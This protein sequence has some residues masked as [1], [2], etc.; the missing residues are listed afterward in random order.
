MK[1]I[2][3]SPELYK[4][5][6]KYAY[7]LCKN[8][9]YKLDLVHDGYL[10][11]LKYG[12]PEKVAPELMGAALANH[13]KQ[14]YIRSLKRH[15]NKNIISY[16]NLAIIPDWNYTTLPDENLIL[17]Q[18]KTPDKIKLN[19]KFLNLTNRRFYVKQISL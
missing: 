7:W 4:S 15:S 17:A 6:T 13:I 12:K 9:A 8:N 16:D 10:R 3:L 5:L 1:P 2:E 18:L 11:F 19:Y 14:A